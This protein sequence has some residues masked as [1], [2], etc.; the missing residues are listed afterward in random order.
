MSRPPALTAL[1]VATLGLAA[2]TLTLHPR[3]AI[4][5]IV[6]CLLLHAARYTRLAIVLLLVLM[7]A[8]LAGIRVDAA[9]PAAPRPER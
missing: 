7:I 4:P 1:G 6:L 3:A 5:A 2:A 8:T 9:P